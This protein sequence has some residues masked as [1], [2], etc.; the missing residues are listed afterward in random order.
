[1]KKAFILPVAAAMSVGAVLAGCTTTGPD[2]LKRYQK[3][4]TVASG[5]RTKLGAAF[6]LN[7]DC[8]AKAVPEVRIREAPKHGKV[9]SLRELA[10]PNSKGEYKKCAST[11]VIA[12]V[13][14]YTPDKGFVGKDRVVVRTSYR[15]GVVDEGVINITVVE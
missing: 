5:E 15:N 6:S 14:Y 12:T 7:P 1:M 9:E 2:G 8:T 4:I 11:K 13:G 10:F 3:N